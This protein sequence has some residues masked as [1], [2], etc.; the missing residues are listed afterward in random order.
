MLWVFMAASVKLLGCK[1]LLEV[2]AFLLSPR[3]TCEL[4]L[5]SGLRSS[6]LNVVYRF[7]PFTTLENNRLEQKYVHRI[8]QNYFQK[9]M[10]L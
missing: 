10:R 7:I 4:V 6:K 2:Y 8:L 3:I 9:T 1:G 5:N